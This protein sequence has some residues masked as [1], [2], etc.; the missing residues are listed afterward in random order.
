MRLYH[1]VAST[2]P[3]GVI[4]GRKFHPYLPRKA[5]IIIDRQGKRRPTIALMKRLIVQVIGKMIKAYI[6]TYIPP[7][8]HP[9]RINHF[10]APLALVSH[11]LRGHHS[12][13][14]AIYIGQSYEVIAQMIVKQIYRERSP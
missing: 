7:R 2:L 8:Q 13:S 10:Q 4:T 14:L 1:L 12:L 5:N 6:G 9:T 3:F 11:V